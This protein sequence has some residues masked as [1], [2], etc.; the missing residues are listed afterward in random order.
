MNTVMQEYRTRK[1]IGPGTCGE[2]FCPV[3]GG[4]AHPVRVIYVVI[5]RD[6]MVLGRTLSVFLP[7]QQ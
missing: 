1:S 6:L 2:V 4:S 3:T 5:V 7:D